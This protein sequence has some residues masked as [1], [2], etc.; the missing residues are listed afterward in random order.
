[1]KKLT[2]ALIILIYNSAINAQS[3]LPTL[4]IGIAARLPAIEL[5]QQKFVQANNFYTAQYQEAMPRLCV[6]VK[7]KIFKKRMYFVQLSNYITYSNSRTIKPL[8]GSSKSTKEYK[9]KRDHFVDIYF[10]FKSSKNIN[11]ILGTG[12]GTMNAG[13]K[14]KLDTLNNPSLPVP[15]QKVN[16]T[17]YMAPRLLLGLQKER[18]HVFAIIHGTPNKNGEPYPTL[19][20]EVKFTYSIYPFKKLKL[21]VVKRE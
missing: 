7:Q 10:Q 18:Y 4:G 5:Q 11:F 21:E 15:I 20:S 6:D 14:F 13:T 3:N 17:T 1:M 12:I 16:A 9:L 19:W 8:P 2:L